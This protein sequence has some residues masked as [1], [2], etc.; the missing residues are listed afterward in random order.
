MAK[1]AQQFLTKCKQILAVPFILLVR[2][3][4]LV[5]SPLLP[6][7]CRFMP[8]CS[9]YMVEA[10]KTYGLFRGLYL[11]IKRIGRCHPFGGSGYDPV[12]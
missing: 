6:A 4:Q 1:K 11:G 7:S 9:T 12:P 10:L 2:L 3:Y 8:T 5:L